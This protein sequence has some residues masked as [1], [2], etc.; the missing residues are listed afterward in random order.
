MPKLVPNSLQQPAVDMG[1]TAAD[2]SKEVEELQQLAHISPTQLKPSN[3]APQRLPALR[4]AC[5]AGFAL[6][7]ASQ[8]QAET[9]VCYRLCYRW[10]G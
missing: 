6:V 9:I 1:L 8:K 4:G 3:L 5:L 2:C 10:P 7:S